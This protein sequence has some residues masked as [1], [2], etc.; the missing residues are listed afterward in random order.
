M[1]G[2]RL[3]LPRELRSAG[4]L[5]EGDL[6]EVTFVN[7]EYRL[8]PVITIS[9]DA[10]RAELKA[11]FAKNRKA[12]KHMSEQEIEDMVEQAVQAVR[13]TTPLNE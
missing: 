12:A 11:A 4:N 1:K 7:G 13:S 5:K 6:V 3:T 8:K 9:A 2:G 10:A